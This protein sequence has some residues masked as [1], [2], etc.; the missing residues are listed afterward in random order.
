MSCEEKALYLCKKVDIIWD[1]SN[2]FSV[3]NLNS[4]VFWKLEVL[5]EFFFH[6]GH[7]KE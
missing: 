2:D 1:Y 7:D 6:H 5:K 3:L 4:W